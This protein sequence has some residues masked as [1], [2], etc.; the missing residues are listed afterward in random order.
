MIRIG[1]P[2]AMPVFADSELEAQSAH[3]DKDFNKEM[4][5]FSH[6]GQMLDFADS[7]LEAPSAHFDKDF[8][9]E[10]IRRVLARMSVLTGSGARDRVPGRKDGRRA[11]RNG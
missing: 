10:M 1:H 11:G 9:K 7:G 8:N 6:P 4:I 2:G 5:R 3:F